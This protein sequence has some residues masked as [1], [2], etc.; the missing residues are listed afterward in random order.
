MPP[1]DT[2]SATHTLR[3]VD[4]LNDRVEPK[5]G[6][7]QTLGTYL[8]AVREYQGRA[9]VDIAA[10][11][12]IR[13]PYLQALEDGAYSTLPSRP[14][15]IGYVR[16]Y[17]AALGLNE[18]AAVERF[19]AEAPSESDAL[20]APVGINY[21]RPERRPLF[22]GV[23]AAVVIAVVGWNIAQRALTTNAP[24]GPDLPVMAPVVA[25]APTPTGPIALGGPIPPPAEQT[26][27]TPYVTPGL[28]QDPALDPAA[29]ATAP[30]APVIA[31]VADR[32]S[33]ATF[34][35]KGAVH[36]PAGAVAAAVLQARKPA[37]LVVRGEGG[38]VHFAR[39]LVAGESYRAPIGQR[40]VIDVSDPASFAVYINGQL[41]GVLS[42]PQT[43]LDKAVAQL[44]ALPE[45]SVLPAP[46]MAGSSVGATPA[47]RPPAVAQV[48]PAAPRTAATAP[49][50]AATAP[51]PAAT[52]PRPAAAAPVRPPVEAPA[53]E[54]PTPAPAEAPL[55]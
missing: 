47:A 48:R 15:A 21:D 26:T 4:P 33:P 25:D 22:L 46:A 11:T 49:R 7:Y 23:A 24:E 3:L 54:E 5:P 20:R 45:P 55:F 42:A 38:A 30:P 32:L 53:A 14:F 2:G 16:A 28:G 29:P 1:L 9:M 17:A 27:P 13:K 50:P 31:P 41:R 18:E 6:E 43:P 12:R 36:G 39:Q 19:K 37:S 51:R 52:A 8:R 35:A 10:A 44:P 40:L 34:V